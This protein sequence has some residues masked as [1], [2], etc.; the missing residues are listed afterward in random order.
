MLE[1]CWQRLHSAI[2]EL[3]DAAEVIDTATPRSFYENTRRKL[4]MVGGIVPPSPAWES[5]AGY[6]TSL[7]NL[8]IVS[9]TTSA[10]GIEV[11]TQ[12]AWDLATT[13]T[14]RAS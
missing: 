12:S 13:L 14:R 2:P 9:D 6:K 8:F 3:G 5:A 7:P 1:Q 10:A 4:G 11:L